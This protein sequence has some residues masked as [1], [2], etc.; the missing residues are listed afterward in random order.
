MKILIY[1]PSNLRAV[2]QQSQAVLFKKMGHEPILLTW[3]PEGD[4]HRNFQ[5]HGFAT[6]S[7]EGVK[8]RRLVF[9]IRQ[10]IYLARFCKQHNIDIV[11]SH[12]QNCA[13]ITGMAK[14]FMKTKVVYVRHHNKFVGIYNSFKEKLQN[15][16][17][18]MLSP[19]IIAISKGVQQQLQ[20][21]GVPARK[22]ARINLCYDFDEY[23]DELTGAYENIRREIASDL[24]IL[25]VGRLTAV[26]RHIKAFEVVEALTKRSINCKLICIGGGELE[27][28]LRQYIDSRDLGRYIILKGFVTNVF[29]YIKASD[30]LLLLSESEASSHMIKEAGMNRKTI[31]AC[32]GV[33][34][35]DDYIVPGKNGFLVDKNDPVPGTVDLLEK[36]SKEKPVLENLGDQLYET[37]YR[38]FSLNGDFIERYNQLFKELNL[39]V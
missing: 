2:D 33:G 35:F 24:T 14:F 10:A 17:A 5:K 15:K 6:Y 11:F 12:L 27:E 7:V 1:S 19:R 22:I 28:E 39:T 37:V 18:N 3:L 36:L 21:E 16:L 38:H 25:Y 34:D 30:L 13:V 31:V 8:G 32:K 26:K 23:A 4:L 29:D 9:F 20:A